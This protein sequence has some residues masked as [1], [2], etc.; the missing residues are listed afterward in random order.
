[1]AANQDK[2]EEKALKELRDKAKAG[3]SSSQIEKE[4]NNQDVAYKIKNNTDKQ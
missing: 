3:K 2:V 4:L 1:M